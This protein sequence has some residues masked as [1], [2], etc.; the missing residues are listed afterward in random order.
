MDQHRALKY[1]IYDV[2]VHIHLCFKSCIL[3][4]NDDP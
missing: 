2:T 1:M 4:P 3:V